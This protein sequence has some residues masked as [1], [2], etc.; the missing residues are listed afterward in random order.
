MSFRA[1]PDGSFVY[2]PDPPRRLAAPEGPGARTACHVRGRVYS[3]AG[4]G[5]EGLQG[6]LDDPAS[7]NSMESDA[8]VVWH[9]ERDDTVRCIRDA[10][11][12]TPVYYA[13]TRKGWAVSFSLGTLLPLMDKPPAPREDTLYDFL[14]THYR[15]IF[16]DP[17]RTFHEGVMQ[18]PAG[19]LLTLSGARADLEPWLDLSFDPEP[20][21]LHPQEAADRYLS[22][23]RENVSLRLSALA[24]SGF[25][26][27][28]SSG[29]DS[30][31]IAA[32]ASDILGAPVE[33]WYVGYSSAKG[34]PYDETRGVQALT[35]A[36]GWALH[37]IDLESPALV[38]E[39]SE[40]MDRTLAPLATVTWLAGGVLARHAAENGCAYLFSGLGGD[41]SL[42]GEFDHFMYFFADLYRD[43]Q[44]ALLER[45]T[46][47]WARLHDHPVF[48]KSK[49]TRDAYFKK[50]IDFRTGEI[51]VDLARYSQNRAWFDEGWVRSM[52]TV[53]PPPPMPG[54]YPYFLSNRLY[55]EMTYETSPP[56]LWSEHLASSANWVKG[57]FPM[58]SPRLFR[59]ALS[60]PGTFKYENGLTKMLL[61]R[62][63]K[64][65]LPEYTR[66][67]PVKTG[68]NVPLDLWL[69]DP[70]TSKEV[71]DVITAS[72][73]PAT[74]WLSPGAPEKILNEHLS[75]QRNHM[76]L[77]WP[78]LSTA[79]FLEKNRRRG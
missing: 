47:H 50:M 54:P 25:A 32:L 29:L 41:E 52:E 46:G 67:N 61:R 60:L 51:R 26:F 31:T 59:F 18:V 13:R 33:C 40:L 44:E 1:N 5:R 55:Q 49:E 63:V 70:K 35:G 77:I 45:E 79:L 65:L 21:T 2:E 76:M 27:T 69:R 3:H 9:D 38:S 28:V 20:G 68:F 72:P 30:S 42:A 58:A 17:R 11:G 66:L 4:E 62:S 7:L 39:T 6:I 16:R 22:M 71:L 15:Y 12:A 56:T 34:S 78:L 36:K 48:R 14:A 19:H 57:I 43:G 73:L 74:G 24:S 8:S 37:P 53:I 23:L 75:G 10:A 64:G